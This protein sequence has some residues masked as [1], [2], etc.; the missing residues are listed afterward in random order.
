MK[1][2]DKIL[3]LL[4]E[5]DGVRS[6][7]LISQELGISRVSVWKHIRGLVD[8]GIP[9]TASAKGYMLEPDED[10]LNPVGFGSRRELIHFHREVPSTMDE[11]V[12]LARGG[13]PDFT[14]VVAQRQTKGRGRMAREWVSDDGGLYFTVVVRPDLPIDLAHLVNLAAAIE[15]S[16][17]LRSSYRINARLKWPNDILVD[18]RKICGCL[19]QMEIEGGLIG[20]LSIGIGLNVNNDPSRAESNGVSMKEILGQSVPRKRILADF[21]DRFEDRLV[22]L[23]PVGLIEDW[24]RHNNTIGK[25][26]SV[27]TRK[28]TYEGVAVD[29]DSHGGLVIEYE[30]GSRD[31]V[32]Y[33]DCFYT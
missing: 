23:D 19:S 31:T 26:V 14:V 18:G 10:N 6:G 7:E 5:S 25:H 16:N 30:N 2:R 20:F 8:S 11:A 21:I 9:I 13:C 24:K 27:V 17:L 12:T 15:I 29:I 4:T 3:K 32:I 28:K 22:S 33:G 1:N